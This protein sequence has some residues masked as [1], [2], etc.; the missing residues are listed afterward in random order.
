MV[1]ST[2]GDVFS[3]DL[4][5]GFSCSF[6]VFSVVTS[7]LGAKELMNCYVESVLSVGSSGALDGGC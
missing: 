3:P 7:S 6:L 5:Y 1:A 4:L 2:L